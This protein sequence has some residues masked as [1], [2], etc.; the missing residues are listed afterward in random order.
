[1]GIRYPINSPLKLDTDITLY[2]QWVSQFFLS[3]NGNGNTAGSVA[4]DT[5]KYDTS[6]T[7]PVAAQNGLYRVGYRFEGW[8]TRPDGS[9]KNWTTNFTP[10]QSVLGGITLYANWIEVFP[11]ISVGREFSVILT[12]QGNIFAAGEGEYGRLGQGN[13]NRTDYNSWQQ[14]ALPPGAAPKAI[15]SGLFHTFILREDGTSVSWGRNYWNAQGGTSS[16]SNNDFNV[17]SP[18]NLLGDFGTNGIIAKLST[19][20]ANSAFLSTNGEYW[21]LGSNYHGN[22]GNGRNTGQ[23]SWQPERITKGFGEARIKDVCAGF[24]STFVITADG[25]LWAAG[26][27]NGGRLGTGNTSLQGSFVKISGMGAD[28][29]KVFVDAAEFDWNVSGNTYLLNTDGSLYGSGFNERGELGRGSTG[30][31][32][33]FA[34]VQQTDKNGSTNMGNVNTVS[35]GLYFALILK[36]DGTLWA[37]GEGDDFRLGLNSTLDQTRAVKILDNVARIAAAHRHSLIVLTDGTVYGVG[38]NNMGQFGNGNTV[39][40]TSSAPMVQITL[41]VEP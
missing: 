20:S 8:N 35:A 32:T 16:V 31:K 6:I 25:E 28:N 29:A 1:L 40:S 17:Y 12:A 15:V 27:G 19:L 23:N 7:I 22:L 24:E 34:P 3:Y 36:N 26:R 39:S 2:A 5:I 21:G 10:D 14:V 30:A 41:P 33:T 18:T 11:K 38:L 37:V 4:P 13:L 9:G